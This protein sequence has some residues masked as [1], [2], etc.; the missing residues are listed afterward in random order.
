VLERRETNAAFVIVA[1]ITGLVP[2]IFVWKQTTRIDLL[3]TAE[4]QQQ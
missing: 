2:V 1:V 4:G 3:K